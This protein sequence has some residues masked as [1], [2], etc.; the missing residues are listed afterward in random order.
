VR[1]EC[2]TIQDFVDSIKGHEKSTCGKLLY[3]I[4]YV[5]QTKNPVNGNSPR[6]ATSFE[7][8]LQ[9]SCVFINGD[10]TEVLIVGGESCG[11]DRETADGAYDGTKRKNELLLIIEQFTEERGIAVVPGT[12]SAT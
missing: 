5:S 3:N 6:S 2:E 11:I 1:V 9:A 4:L 12:A 7:I 10:D 8:I